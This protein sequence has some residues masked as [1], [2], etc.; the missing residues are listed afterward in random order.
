MQKE[1]EAIIEDLSNQIKTYMT[2]Y[3]LDEL[4]G[5]EHKATYKMVSSER[6]DAKALKEAHPRI[7][8]QYTVDNSYMRLNFR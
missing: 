7:A 3:N 6:L 8:K 4:K 2:R 1:T 5:D